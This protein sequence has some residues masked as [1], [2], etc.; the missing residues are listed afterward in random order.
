MD[1]SNEQANGFT[2]DEFEGD[3]EIV[4]KVTAEPLN[5]EALQPVIDH[6]IR[7][8]FTDAVEGSLNPQVF[9]DLA[10]K[11]NMSVAD[12]IDRVRRVV[13]YFQ[14]QA[15]SLISKEGIDPNEFYH[16]ARTERND[17]LKEAMRLHAYGRTLDGY[18]TLIDTFWKSRPVDPKA[19][20]EAAAKG[21][22]KTRTV[23]DRTMVTIP[24]KPEVDIDVAVRL[25]WI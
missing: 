25:G 19:L 8:S 14:T 15:D 9:Q 7:L 5:Q 4:V 17:Q 10:D 6:I 20:N 23:G 12:A 13:G 22:L 24:G 11:S 16:W 2:I 18:R 21:L 1:Q 3:G